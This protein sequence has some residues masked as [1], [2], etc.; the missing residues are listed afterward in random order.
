MDMELEGIML[1]KIS[2]MEKEL[3]GFTLM[4]N[5]RKSEEDHKGEEGN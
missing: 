2:H 4:S 3:C 1:N 5:V